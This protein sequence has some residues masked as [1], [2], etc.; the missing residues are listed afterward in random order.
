ME[1]ETGGSIT[2][3]HDLVVLATGYEYRMPMT[4]L[5]GLNGHLELDEQG[6]Y[7]IGKDY[8]LRSALNAGVYLQG[9][10]ESTHGFSEVLLSLMPHRAAEIVRSLSCGLPAREAAYALSPVGEA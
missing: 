2:E 6:G 10:G 5:G 3:E 4:M 1:L 9:Y 8:K 7:V